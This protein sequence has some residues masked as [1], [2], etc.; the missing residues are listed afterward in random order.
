MTLKNNPTFLFLYSIA[1]LV[2]FKNEFSNKVCRTQI[3]I[4]THWQFNYF[5]CRR[6]YLITYSQKNSPLNT[7][8]WAHDPQFE[9][10]WR[11]MKHAYCDLFPDSEHLILSKHTE[12]HSWHTH[13]SKPLVKSFQHFKPTKWGFSM[14]RIWSKG[15]ASQWAIQRPTS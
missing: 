10:Q 6:K 11:R 5:H 3:Y 12:F 8:F 4:L 15:S 1:F 2:H 13:F 9:I 7:G 14:L